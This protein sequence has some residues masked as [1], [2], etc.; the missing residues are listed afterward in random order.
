MIKVLVLSGGKSEEREVSLRSGASVKAALT[1]AGYEVGEF[2]PAT[3]LTRNVLAGYEVVFPV[4]HG[5]GGEDGS[6]QARL[7]D[8]GVRYVGTGAAASA[9]CFDKWR[10]KQLLLANGLPTPRGAL[11]DEAA[12][13]ESELSRSPFALKPHDGGSSIDNLM[14]RDGHQGPDKTTVSE[15][16]KR[17]PHMLLEELIA[18]Q[19]ITLSVLDQAALP[20]I[21]IIPP[22]SGEFD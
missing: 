17:H 8:F 2:D 19:E 21:E 16:F 3:P 11:V 7:D 15:L 4:L 18:G 20:V 12:F 10:Y 9:L 22:E 13:W 5:A 6:L 14:V 1:Q